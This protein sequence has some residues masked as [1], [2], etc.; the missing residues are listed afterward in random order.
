M[1]I[2]GSAARPPQDVVCFA[3]LRKN[4]VLFE[5]TSFSTIIES[6]AA[7]PHSKPLAVLFYSLL[8]PVSFEVSPPFKS[9]VWLWQNAARSI[10]WFMVLALRFPLK[11]PLLFHSRLCRRRDDLDDAG[12]LQ[13]PD[14]VGDRL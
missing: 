5:H 4:L 8:T 14:R 7:Q 11:A 9:G 2:R 6:R 13:V 12:S 3:V 10:S 1:L